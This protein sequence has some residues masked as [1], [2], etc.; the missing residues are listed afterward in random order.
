MAPFLLMPVSRFIVY[1]IVLSPLSPLLTSF[2]SAVYFRLEHLKVTCSQPLSSSESAL[3]APVH[4]KKK[5]A[6]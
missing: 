5:L 6:Y 3:I 2:F 4:Y 1:P